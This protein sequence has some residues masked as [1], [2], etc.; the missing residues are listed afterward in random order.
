LKEG[1]M[2][3][4]DG[5]KFS[6][7]GDRR[8]GTAELSVR[9][10]VL[11]AVVAAVMGA[12]NV[13]IGLKVGM[14]VCASIPAAVL[15]IAILRGL[16]RG[17]GVLEHN[18]V[19]TTGS[20][21]ESLAAGIIFTMPA[22]I[23]AGVWSE[24]DF[25]TVSLVALLGG[26]LGVFFMV[27]LRRSLM[28]DEEK[29]LRYPEGVACAQVLYAG[30]KSGRGVWLLLI[31]GLIGLL[32][33][34]VG[35]MMGCST[36]L[37]GAVGLGGGAVVMLSFDLA[38]A[39]LAVGAIIGPV[40]ALLVL[41]G[42]AVTFLALIPFHLA[43]H[44]E[45]G[46]NVWGAY[47]TCRY[48]GVGAMVVG[49][50]W[51]IVR[52]RKSIR[53]A[54]SRLFEK[55]SPT[56]KEALLARR[57]DL[58]AKPLF[59][60]A[61]L[62][63]VGVF[64]LYWHVLGSLPY[65]ILASVAMLVAGFFFVAVSSYVVGLVGS[66]SNPV[67]GMTICTLLFAALLLLPLGLAG[68]AAVLALLVVS[69]VVCCA[70][71]TAGDIS[72]D[73]KTGHLVGAKPYKQQLAQ[74]L[75]VVAAAFVMAPVL[76]MLPKAYT[77]SPPHGGAK[78]AAEAENGDAGKAAG[79]EVLKAPQATMFA[80]LASLLAHWET[81]ADREAREAARR[82]GKELPK[83]EI[84]WGYLLFGVLLALGLGVGDVFLSRAKSSFRLYIMPAAVG[85]Y[86]PLGLGVTITAGALLVW[87]MG[88]SL[89]RERRKAWQHAAVLLA[90]GLI[91][92]EAFAGI[93]TAPLLGAGVTW[94]TWFSGRSIIP[95][96]TVAAAV[97]AYV[98]LRFS[99]RREET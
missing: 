59:A 30:G 62:V 67:S 23:I 72:Q 76:T 16:L 32:G 85:L 18:I 9:A 4:I 1:E 55:I 66:S 8:R 38:V 34:G 98:W 83:R 54:L 6:P 60:A 53:Q 86:L 27:P 47:P 46:G 99:K 39:P 40:I 82:E 73:L 87:F 22:L 13:Y 17:G 5:R 88:R 2:E 91:A 61:G 20:A 89:S 64:F 96:L 21:G 44:P 15:S 37:A 52:M 51:S 68:K 24:F 41:I 10:L 94:S 92:G 79:K 33:T 95:A 77:F 29:T 14:T 36:E 70:A 3:P 84:P 97:V 80:Q 71:A 74:I 42:S 49:G 90:S 63:A 31:G 75:G 56:Q 65:A 26:L 58:P 28:V 25:W 93:G 69:G 50:L 7:Y 19:Q 45:L 81:P 48:A 11:G 12:A 78:K 57:E 43:N 35:R